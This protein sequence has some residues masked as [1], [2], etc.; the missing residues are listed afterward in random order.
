M[1]PVSVLQEKEMSAVHYPL[2]VD[3][4]DTLLDGDMLY[5]VFWNALRAK[6][7][8]TLIALLSLI[9]SR[10]SLKSSLSKL[11]KVEPHLLS[12]NQKVIDYIKEQKKMGRKVVLA[13]ASHLTWAT[14]V[15]EHL[16]LFDDV[17]GSDDT[18]NLKGESKAKELLS[19]YSEFEYIG[20]S[21]ADFSV[22]KVAARG[23]VVSST[24]TFLNEV[25]EKFPH[26]YEL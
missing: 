15:A 20:D 16:K 19:R 11:Y 12:F 8:K 9:R 5:I 25:S 26:V 1:L 24:S 18:V 17:L 23:R 7:I 4:D 14:V 21:Y 6:P 3:L 13:T 10:A 22:W 2:C